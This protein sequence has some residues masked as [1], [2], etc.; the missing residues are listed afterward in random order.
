MSEKN[1]MQISGQISDRFRRAM[2]KRSKW[3]ALWR[4]CYAYALPQYDGVT[5]SS[6]PGEVRTATLFDGTAPDGVDQLASSLLG[7]LTPPWGRW[8]SLTAGSEASPEAAADAAKA[9]EFVSDT[10]RG[11]FERSNFA[12]EMHQCFLD[13]VTVGTACLLFEEAPAGSN[14]AFQFT[15]IPLGQ[16]AF[17]EGQGGKLD[18]T[19]RR[20]ELSAEVFVQRFPNAALPDQSASGKSDPQR[21]AVIESV[22]PKDGGFEYSA[23]RAN[24]AKTNSDDN[25]LASGTFKQSPFINFRWLKAPGEVY[26]RSPVMKALPDIK[27]ANKVVELVLKNASIAVTGIWQADDDGVLNPATIQLTPG[28]IIPKAVGSQGLTPL[29]APGS[30]DVS[31]LVLDDLRNRIKSALLVDKLGQPSAPAMTATEVLT[32]S[33]EISRMLGATYGRLQSELLVPLMNRALSVLSR[34]GDIPE[35]NLDGRAIAMTWRSPLARSY[36]RHEAREAMQWM[37]AIKTLGPE[38]TSQI[39]TVSA[40][41]WLAKAFDVPE[42]ILKSGNNTNSTDNTDN[43]GDV[44][45]A[46]LADALATT[47]PVPIAPLPVPTQIAEEGPR[48]GK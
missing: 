7:E 12:I 26:G 45:G 37:E 30:F 6:N 5:Q 21:I 15:A 34:R 8:F 28:T 39:D 9:L 22:R 3:D 47:P 11:H 2:E 35:I 29:S 46:A 18:T 42:S 40:V 33:A 48:H 43:T 32:R 24:M 19:Y 10:V 1:T 44:L 17:E 14:S 27:T 16:I 20:S 38:A 23:V 41:Q 36:S 25:I 13:L 4:E 31:Q